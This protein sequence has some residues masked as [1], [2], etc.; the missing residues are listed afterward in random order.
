MTDRIIRTDVFMQPVARDGAIHLLFSEKDH[1]TGEMRPTAV[2]NMLIPAADALTLSTVVADLAFEADTGLKAAGP[3][4][5]AELIERHRKTLTDRIAVV[6]NSQRERKTV[7][8]R[9]LAR[10]LV[11]LALSEVFE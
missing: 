2:D 9:Q 7:T 1:Q 5:K 8:N 3:A 11:D 4:L 6:L 10:K